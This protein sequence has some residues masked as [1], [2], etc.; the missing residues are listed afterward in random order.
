MQVLIGT[1]IGVVKA[2]SIKRRPAG[3]RW[4]NRLVSNMKGT[5]KSMRQGV[6]ET[7]QEDPGWE[8]A[9]ITETMEKEEEHRARPRL[10]L[11]GRDF[12]RYGYT[13]E[14]VGCIGMA[15]KAP[16]RITTTKTAGR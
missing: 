14:C 3:E 12:K 8:E 7:T 15:R 6:P 13:H 16:R 1:S 4:S 10:Y 9:P 2:W 11:R 5:P